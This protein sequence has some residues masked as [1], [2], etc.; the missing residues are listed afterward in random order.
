MS[1]SASTIR[2]GRIFTFTYALEGKSKKMAKNCNFNLS[3]S[4]Q[5]SYISENMRCF[6]P[7]FNSFLASV[8]SFTLSSYHCQNQ[9]S[10]ARS[11]PM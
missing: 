4:A 10:Q 2:T 7:I 5:W 9:E 6:T 3:F 1:K 8:H 11:D